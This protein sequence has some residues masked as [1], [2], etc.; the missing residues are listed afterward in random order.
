MLRLQCRRNGRGRQPP[1]R[2]ASS[3][4]RSSACLRRPI[5]SVVRRPVRRL[6]VIPRHG[7]AGHAPVTAEAASEEH[8]KLPSMSLSRL[9]LSIVSNLVFVLLRKVAVRDGLV[10]LRL[11][12][13]RDE[14]LQ[15]VAALAVRLGDGRER[16]V[17]GLQAPSSSASVVMPRKSASCCR[18]ASQPHP[19]AEAE[20]RAALGTVE[21]S[22]AL[23]PAEPV[24]AEAAGGAFW[25]RSFSAS[26]CFCVRSPLATAAVDV[27]VPRVRDR[28]LQL[29]R[30]DA[31]LL[32]RRGRGTSN[33]S[34]SPVDLRHDG[35]ARPAPRPAPHPP[36]RSAIFV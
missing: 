24:L 5:R 17:V 8:A 15:L 25:M 10:E 4:A 7:A 18:R 32:R 28:L 33:R 1:C 14:C 21:P 30:V 35:A 16:R 13:V 34:P 27:F 6:V 31:E 22:E 11:R 19:E 2:S 26:A 20:A 9:S 36:L 23:R 29:R 3:A 12:R